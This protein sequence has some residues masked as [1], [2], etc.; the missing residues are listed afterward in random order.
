MPSIP[1]T[2][3]YQR[4]YFKWG[5]GLLKWGMSSGT[6]GQMINGFI[7]RTAL[8]Q[9]FSQLGHSRLPSALKKFNYGC[10]SK[11]VKLCWCSSVQRRLD[12]LNIGIIFGTIQHL[13][14]RIWISLM[15]SWASTISKRSCRSRVTLIVGLPSR[16]TLFWIISSKI[17]SIFHKFSQISSQIL[18]FL[19][20]WLAGWNN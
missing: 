17:S 2:M 6:K 14:S 20:A 3:K 8:T 1:N 11:K 15:M 19:P 9:Y 7:N 4:V 10:T 16:L 18:H 13:S 5:Q 12:T